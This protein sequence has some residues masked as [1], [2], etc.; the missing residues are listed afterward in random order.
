MWERVKS[1]CLSHLRWTQEASRTGPDQR[2]RA[3]GP[4][5]GATWSAVRRGAKAGFLFASRGFRSDL[6]ANSS[7]GCPLL[8]SS[9]VQDGARGGRRS[10]ETREG[11]Y[12]DKIICLDRHNRLI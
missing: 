6:S 4:A 10:G 9:C 5:F 7:T 11:S 3:T 12:V 8:S 2:N 1:D